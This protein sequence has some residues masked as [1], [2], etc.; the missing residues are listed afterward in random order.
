MSAFCLFPPH[1][2]CGIVVQNC[3]GS[4]LLTPKPVLEVHKCL[5]PLWHCNSKKGV[6]IGQNCFQNKTIAVCVFG[7]VSC[8][9]NYSFGLK[10]AK[11]N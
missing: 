11:I 8:S 9:N 4:T 3:L 10:L 6:V 1:H 2:S 7:G 5:K